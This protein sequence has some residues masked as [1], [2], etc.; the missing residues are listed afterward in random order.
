MLHVAGAPPLRLELPSPALA[1]RQQVVEEA[2]LAALRRENVELRTPHRAVTIEQTHDHVDVRVMRRELVT[3]GSPAHYSEWEPLE[4]SIVRASFVIGADGYESRVRTA[5]GLE[6]VKVGN[7]EA[8]AMFE[9]ENEGDL[10]SALHLSFDADASS[11]MLPLPERRARWGFQL[12][13]GLDAEPDLNRLRMLQSQR[14][15]W[16]DG[17]AATVAWGTVIHFERRLARRFGKHRV[18]LAGDAAHVTSPL[19][20]QSMNAGLIEAHALANRMADAVDG[21]QGLDALDRCGSE[22]A[23]EWHKLLGVNV[24]LDL[25]PHAPEWLPAYARRLLPALPVSGADLTTV[26][27][28]IG[29]RLS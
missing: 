7:T 21:S 27:E 15:P 12:Q 8:F 26:L 20:S 23:R 14:T 1:V 4:S 17:A 29:L 28:R 3:L 25:L 13:D 10:D 22:R 6:L 16:Y 18:W 2:L 9:S 11:L 24:R 5:L 19:G